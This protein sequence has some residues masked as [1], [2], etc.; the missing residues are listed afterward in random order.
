MNRKFLTSLLFTTLLITSCNGKTKTSEIGTA[1]RTEKT[2][3]VENDIIRISY[4]QKINGYQ[5]NV[6]WKPK[7]LRYDNAVGP[8]IL[9]FSNGESEFTLTNNYFAL[10]V[11]LFDLKTSENSIIGINKSQVSIDYNE[12]NIGNDTFESIDVPFLFIDLN[13]DGNKEILLTKSGQG[14]SFGDSYDAYSFDNR[15]LEPD[16]YQITNQSPFSEIDFF[17]RLDAENKE[18]ILYGS[19]GVCFGTAQTYS[20]KNDRFELTKII[21]MERDDDA[22]KCYEL[23]Y[24]VE[25]GIE[26]L[27]SKKEIEQ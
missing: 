19:G 3:N 7:T 12:P 8:A 5:V 26:K 11:K 20:L 17:T 21:R 1:H 22:E 25:N 15:E 2:E 18:L 23:I 27:V 16:L 10:P 9:E 6:I 4:N 14:Q 13:F 24:T